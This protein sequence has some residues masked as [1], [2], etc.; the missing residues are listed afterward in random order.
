MIDARD[1]TKREIRANDRVVYPVRQG[2]RMWLKELIVRQVSAGPG[3]KP[4]ISGAN[5]KGRLVTIKNLDNVV[6]VPPAEV[7]ST[8]TPATTE[9]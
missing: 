4:Q 8:D 5:A 3:G 6:V 1:F 9:V 2:S 7:S